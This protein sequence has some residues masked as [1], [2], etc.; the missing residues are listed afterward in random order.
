MQNC[1]YH[2]FQISDLA[3]KIGHYEFITSYYNQI[4]EFL[5]ELLQNDSLEK[6]AY[7]RLLYI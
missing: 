6:T 7:D 2:A 4:G 3:D 5:N 1:E